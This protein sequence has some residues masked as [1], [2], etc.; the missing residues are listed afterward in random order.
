MLAAPYVLALTSEAE[1]ATYTFIGAGDTAG[2]SWTQDTATGDLV[3]AHPGA[4]VWTAG[5]NAY[6]SGT[7]TSFKDCYGPAWGSFKARTKPTPGNRE[8]RTAGANGYFSYFPVPAYYAYN[9]G[10]NWRIYAPN[11]NIGPGVGALNTTGFATIS[12]RTRVHA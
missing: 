3:R 10:T 7:L 4:T 6:P 1:G 2:C 12:P 8:Y 11:S 5:D 9:L